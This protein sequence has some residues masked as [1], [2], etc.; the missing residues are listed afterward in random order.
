LAT[1]LGRPDRAQEH[2]AAALSLDAAAGRALAE[3]TRGWAADVDAAGLSR[4]VL[5]GTAPQHQPRR[6]T[7]SLPAPWRRR[8]RDTGRF[9]RDGPVWTLEFAGQTVRLADTKGLRDLAVLL[10]RPGER[11]HVSELCAAGTEQPDAGP[12][13]D[14]RALAAYRA[15]LGE[16]ADEI[17]D[18]GYAADAGRA[19]R[20]ARE[21]EALLAELSSVTGLGGSSRRAGSDTERMRKAVHN[22]VRQ[23]IE[24]ITEAHPELG[25]HLRASV[26]T[27][28]YCGY[29]PEHPVR[30]SL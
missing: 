5:V 27:G 24:R 14:R 8:P 1:F 30:W 23:A 4:E 7:P 15:R 22:R 17:A 6:A 2:F 29:Q 12:L 20:A 13:A 9:R 11:T 19:E 26:H 10:R 3:R 21:R 28:S 18:A 16:L 25:R